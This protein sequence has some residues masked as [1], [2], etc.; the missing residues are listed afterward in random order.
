MTRSQSWSDMFLND[1]SPEGKL[2]GVVSSSEEPELTQYARIVDEDVDGPEC[3]DGG[4][5]DSLALCNGSWSSDSFA[6][7]YYVSLIRVLKISADLPLVLR[8]L[9]GPL[10]PR[11]R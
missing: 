4:I 10:G 9:L 2:D 11:H 6:S 5:D 7:T 8:L 1:L 3:F